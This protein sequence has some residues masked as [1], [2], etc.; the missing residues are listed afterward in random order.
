VAGCGVDCRYRIEV[1]VCISDQGNTKMSPNYVQKHDNRLHL[2]RN[3]DPY[4]E[5]G[6]WNERSA[7]VGE[8]LLVIYNKATRAP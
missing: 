2:Q 1:H 3:I 6:E 7:C 8:S 4:I 5:L